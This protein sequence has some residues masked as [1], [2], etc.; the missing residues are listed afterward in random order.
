M[1]HL[2]DCVAL[3]R[4]TTC[5][6][7]S[8]V[9]MLWHALLAAGSSEGREGLQPAAASE[10]SALLAKVSDIAR[11]VGLSGDDSRGGGAQGSHGRRR[12]PVGHIRAI[13][14]RAQA[15]TWVRRVVACAAAHHLMICCTN[16]SCAVSLFV[17]P[18][19]QCSSLKMYY[20]MIWFAF[21]SIAHLF[22]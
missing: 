4:C 20:H 12:L 5:A 15:N 11:R 6:A 7:E 21:A 18:L 17:S 19:L 2:S 3:S 14:A 13:L 10:L 9:M 22:A 16:M 1:A 8:N